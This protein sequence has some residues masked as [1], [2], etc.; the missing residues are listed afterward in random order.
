MLFPGAR[1]D[2]WNDNGQRF[3]FG[4]FSKY[5]AA[6]EPRG[7]HLQRLCRAGWA[8]LVRAR[9]FDADIAEPRAAPSDGAHAWSG[10]AGKVGQHIAGDRVARPDEPDFQDVDRKWLRHGAD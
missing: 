8:K 4:E 6:F 3:F 1:G 9:L 7:Q 10:H 2:Q 5:V